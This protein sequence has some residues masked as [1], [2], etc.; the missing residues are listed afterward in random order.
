MPKLFKK[1]KS[2][3]KSKQLGM[4]EKGIG[5]FCLTYYNYKIWGVWGGQQPR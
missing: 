2:K 5:G 4:Y 1:H 3:G